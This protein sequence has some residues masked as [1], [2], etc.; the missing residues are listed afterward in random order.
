MCHAWV[1]WIIRSDR[2]KRFLFAPLE[3]ATAKELLSALLP[4]YM[5]ED[6]L[7]YYDN[8]AIYLRSDAGLRI[9]KDLG[10]PYS[11][12]SGFRFVPKFLRDLV[13][14]WIASRRYKYGKRYESCPLP[15]VEWRERFLS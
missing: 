5:K 2:D 4:G 9:L 7:V 13:Y 1:K 15:P 10:S 8:G 11:V 12:I 14:R 6:T 3:S